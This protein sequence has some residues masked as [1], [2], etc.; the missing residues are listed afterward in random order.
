MNDVSRFGLGMSGI[1]LHGNL[2]STFNYSNPN[3]YLTSCPTN[4]APYYNSSAAGSS[5]NP[6]NLDMDLQ[7]YSDPAHGAAQ[8]SPEGFYAGFNRNQ[9]MEPSPEPSVDVSVTP[10]SDTG[11]L[12]PGHLSGMPSDI[13]PGNLFGSFTPPPSVPATPEPQVQTDME[14]S[15]GDDFFNIGNNDSLQN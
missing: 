4:Y 12:D 6:A 8:V 13:K 11:L 1:D 9:W 10:M 14:K 2:N 3:A 15:L 7:A 5:L